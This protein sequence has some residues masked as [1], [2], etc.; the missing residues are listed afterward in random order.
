MLALVFAASLSAQQPAERSAQPADYMIGA[1]DVLMIT[2]YDQADLSGKF[3]VEADGTLTFPLLGRVQVGGMTLR[4]VEAAL[5]NQLVERGFFRRPQITVS[6]DE[7][8]SQK[9][10]ILGEVRTPGVYPLAGAMHLVEALA[11]AD[12][13]LPTAGR[14]IVIV[15]ATDNPSRQQDQD[16]VRIDLD[17]LE[18]GEQNVALRDGDTILVP[19]ADDVYVFGQVNN[20]GAYP[21][22]EK[23]MTVLQ[24]LSL[25]GGLT[26][27]GSTGRIEIVRIVDGERQEI[28]AEL[29][30]FLLPGD[31][32]IVPER[33]F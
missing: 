18:N 30:D 13:T 10:F 15:P 32:I 6:I 7:Y 8:R 31:T 33:F 17:D 23:D 4:A 19:R 12:S 5:K 11:L 29:T 26:D 21:L 28:S 22:R 3:A 1:H 2:S 16:V 24:A 14:E 20:P 9:I 25:A 27:R